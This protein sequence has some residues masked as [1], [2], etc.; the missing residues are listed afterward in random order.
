MAAWAN[1][2]G[3]TATVRVGA[4]VQSVTVSSAFVM[5]SADEVLT[6]KHSYSLSDEGQPEYIRHTL[7]PC[8]PTILGCPKVIEGPLTF[9]RSQ[10]TNAANDFGQPKLYALVERDY[11]TRPTGAPWD[12]VFRFQF[13]RSG[14]GSTFD[15]GG[16]ASTYMTPAGFDLAK[17][18]A[19]GA[20]L[21]YYHRPTVP[22][23]GGYLEPPN[24][25]NPF[26]RATLA[27][28][29]RD[30]GN[31]LNAAGYPVE[32]AVYDLFMARGYRGLP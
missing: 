5:S 24:L 21:V 30:L 11:R 28:P 26:W 23:G 25:F 32:G 9:N 10:L 14:S 4:C 18:V 1:D 8:P 19:V 15:N 16:P 7:L 31:R 3:G 2:H 6:D 29:D 17:Q 12:L 27:E 22:G 20:G 13:S